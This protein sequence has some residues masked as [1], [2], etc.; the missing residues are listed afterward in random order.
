M[1]M[2]SLIFAGKKVGLRLFQ[3][4][5]KLVLTEEGRESWVMNDFQNICKNVK[6]TGQFK[7]T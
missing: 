2:T 7:S 4:Q 3:Q 5:R 6:I 1:K